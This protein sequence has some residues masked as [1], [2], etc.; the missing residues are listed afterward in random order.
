MRLSAPIVATARELDRSIENDPMP[1]ET[2]IALG[3]GEAD[4]VAAN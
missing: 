2:L 4:P 1:A 3:V